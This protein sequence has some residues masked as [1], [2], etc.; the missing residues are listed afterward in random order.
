S[1]VFPYS[2]TVDFPTDDVDPIPTNGQVR[3][4]NNDVLVIDTYNRSVTYNGETVGHRNRLKVLT[5]WV[6]FAPGDNVIQ[7]FDNITRSPIVR[8]QIT[9]NVMLLETERAH[10]L[11]PGESVNVEIPV[12]QN[13]AFKGL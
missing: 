7:F 8:K 9:N 5:D 10:F 11:I 3:L 13:L 4:V 12:T 1:D 2:F 6:K